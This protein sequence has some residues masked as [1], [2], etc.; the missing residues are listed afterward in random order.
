MRAL[1]DT[2]EK[3]KARVLSKWCEQGQSPKL[4]FD[5]FKRSF[6]SHRCAELS[7]L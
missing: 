3:W 2:H 7:K 1:H 4:E 6:L 5:I